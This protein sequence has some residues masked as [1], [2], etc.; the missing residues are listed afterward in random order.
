MCLF[1]T[2]SNLLKEAKLILAN[3]CANGAQLDGI[4]ARV[5]MIHL[6]KES[7]G[8]QLLQLTILYNFMIKFLSMG[9]YHSALSCS[10][11]LLKLLSARAPGS[12][13]I[14][15]VPF[16]APDEHI[17]AEFATMHAWAWCIKS[18][19]MAALSKE[20]DEIL[21]AISIFCFPWIEYWSL[22]NASLAAQLVG[23][24]TQ[25]IHLCASPALKSGNGD[26]LLHLLSGSLWLFGFA[27]NSAFLSKVSVSWASTLLAGGVAA[28]QEFSSDTAL[29]MG[30]ASLNQGSA[31][32][33]EAVARLV[34]ITEDQLD[35]RTP[36]PG[37]PREKLTKGTCM[38]EGCFSLLS[39]VTAAGVLLPCS[40]AEALQKVSGLCAWLG[41]PT[42]AISVLRLLC[43][44][45]R[46]ANKQPS[47]TPESLCATVLHHNEVSR[48]L[49]ALGYS[50]T[51]KRVHDEGLVLWRQGCAQSEALQ[52]PGVAEETMLCSWDTAM[53]GA[54]LE[55]EQGDLEGGSS[56][57]QRLHT[58][59]CQRG[60]EMG[61][62]HKALLGRLH[63]RCL[64]FLSVASQ[65]LGDLDSALCLAE[66]AL[67]LALPR[68]GEPQ[69]GH[70][71]G[72]CTD[73]FGSTVELVEC[74]LHV[75]TLN[76]LRGC[77]AEAEYGLG[78]L[79]ALVSLGL[80]Q[81]RWVVSPHYLAEG[82][83]HSSALLRLQH[84]FEE[85]EALLQH[86]PG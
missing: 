22:R 74:L 48:V 40:L 54:F 36:S 72:P 5:S 13:H 32:P 16:V 34:T 63:F 68:S 12:N 35:L 18:R 49:A 43:A 38:L 15:G 81:P 51:A 10:E 55:V 19:A 77:A 44:R 2:T 57:L 14:G 83:L 67:S 66:D 27:G 3:N 4:F 59:L 39:C 28:M 33:L 26:L 69:G 17:A 42:G 61:A 20:P 11:C 50:G 31:M 78:Q 30:A 6:D 58:E 73:G 47:Q 23:H 9:M 60:L 41:N 8:Q 76:T 7:E 1:D 37:C 21:R 45:H 75:V 64:H 80:R 84:R 52:G 71:V 65:R 29:L 85:A 70:A 25:A 82:L 46:L 79:R 24:C 62:C 53:T 56:E 86:V